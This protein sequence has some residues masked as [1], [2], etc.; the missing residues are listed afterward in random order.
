MREVDPRL[1]VRQRQLRE[2]GAGLRERLLR[3][4]EVATGAEEPAADVAEP[5]RRPAMPLLHRRLEREEEG[6]G[7]VQ[8]V[9]DD[10]GVRVEVV[11]GPETRFVE[12]ATRASAAP[13]G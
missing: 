2:A 1:L 10:E 8:A 7:L 5:W 9:G 11:P 6:V 13:A 3:A 12:A 4:G